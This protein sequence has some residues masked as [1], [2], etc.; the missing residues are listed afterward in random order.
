MLMTVKEM[1][2]LIMLD[3]SDMKVIVKLGIARLVAPKYLCLQILIISNIV[4]IV[5]FCLFLA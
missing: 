4:K 5:G 2:V 1:N 3:K